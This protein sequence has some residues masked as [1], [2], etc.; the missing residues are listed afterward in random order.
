[1]TISKKAV[2][3]YLA[4]V[5]RFDD[6]SE[7][8]DLSRAELEE[9]VDDLD[10][11]PHFEKRLRDHQLASFLIGVTFPEFL[12]F[13]EPGLGKTALVLNILKYRMEKDEIK[14]A[15]VLVP[16]PTI[17]GTWEKQCDLFSP[18][19]DLLAFRGTTEQRLGMFS[20]ESD[21]SVLNYQGLL[22]AATSKQKGKKKSKQVLDK[23]KIKYI[24]SFYDA[25]VFDES[26]F[27][28][29]H[30]STIYQVCNALVTD[31]PYRYGLTGTPFSD[32]HDVWTQFHL[33]DRG[34]TF[35][36]T[37]GIFR[38]ALFNEKK[39]YWSGFP[40]YKFNKKMTDH[41]NK[42]LKYKSIYYEDSECLDLP[43]IVHDVVELDLAGGA[44]KYYEKFVKEFKE[45]VKGK[46]QEKQNTFLKMRTTA[47]GF[48]G[49][50]TEDTGKIEIKL[51]DN[52]KLDWLINY[53]KSL[54]ENT[55]IVVFHEF[56][57]TSDLIQ[58]ELKKHK[59]K[60]S[61]LNGRTKDPDKAM[62]SFIEDKDTQVFVANSAS[63]G[64]GLDGLQSVAN[65]LVFFESPTSPITR[66]QTIKRVHRDGSNA[67][68]VY[69][70]DLVVRGTVEGNIL[71]SLSEGNDLFQDLMVGRKKL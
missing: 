10:P 50:T 63:G 13:L 64:T 31:I 66:K 49:L 7:I 34:E 6:W 46:V 18:N 62:N 41:F 45:Q 40:E 48:V 56:I 37:L 17:F 35:G 65:R 3:Q 4:Q 20:N 21:I 54:P 33:I 59:I 25:I 44:K 2:N 68:R 38:Q 27:L 42:R 12:Y 36:R 69:I 24:S 47:S 43:K 22:Y 53:I 30:Q 26:H 19:L 61:V 51:P 11:K 14:K 32:P 39:N 60:H 29:N 67:N 15:L 28:K 71:E 9:A 1:M 5:N 57:A 16:T 23:D 55:K 8:K 70:T 52:P 58:D